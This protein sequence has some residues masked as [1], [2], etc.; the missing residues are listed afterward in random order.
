M[1]VSEYVRWGV[2]CLSL[3]WRPM[4]SALLEMCHALPYVSLSHIQL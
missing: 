1:L 2:D 4:T 3:R